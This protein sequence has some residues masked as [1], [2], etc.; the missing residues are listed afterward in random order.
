MIQALL[1]VSILLVQPAPDGGRAPSVLG[2][3]PAAK[4]DEA[5]DSA[6]A[7]AKYNELRAK[8]PRTVAG[9]AKLA[10]WCEEHGLEAEAHV[11][12]TEVVRLDP[13]RE[14]AWRKL[15]FKKHGHRW[16]SEARIAEVEAQKHANRIWLPRLR[17]IHKDIH[18]L[19]GAEKRD[20]A[21][22]AFEAIRDEKAIPSLYQE[23]GGSPTD[24]VLLL[25][26]L[27]RIDKP[28]ATRVLAML[29]V[30]GRTPEVRR[31]ATEILRGR[32][33]RD[34]LEWLVGLLVDP[35]HYEVKPVG[36]PGSPGVLFVEGEEFNTARFYAPPAPPNIVPMP[37]DIISYDQLG[38]PVI[39][40]GLGAVDGRAGAAGPTTLAFGTNAVV[41][42]SASQMMLEALKGAAVA[43][44]Q[45][46]GDV[47]RIQ[48]INDARRHFNK[49][50]IAV[51]S[52]ATGKTLGDDP[53]DWRKA[54]AGVD[55]EKK[56]GKD[57]A[58]KPTLTEL[59][60]VAYRPQF[61]QLDFMVG[62]FADS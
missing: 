5:E 47:A 35:L 57:Q 6:D 20:Q 58:P 55:V 51:A 37:G 14:A 7:L 28:L 17:K 40:R 1:V 29:S 22:T 2:G 36:G 48:S 18:G 10:A 8:T 62:Y 25:Q 16:V 42:Y 46:E 33:S 26:A 23:F 61:G 32:P 38:M 45:L 13:R 50:V 44:S 4:V 43:G 52:S 21:R 31:R 59:V 15:G 34:Y 53:K 49:L 19:S 54:I 24:Q 3:K 12:Y 56:Y 39:T 30:Y 27:D 60:P 9:H 41:R 11:H